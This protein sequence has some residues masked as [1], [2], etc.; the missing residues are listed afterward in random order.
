[1]RLSL[2]DLQPGAYAELRDK[3]SWGLV[4]KLQSNTDTET[5]TVKDADAFI[6]DLLLDLVKEWSLL[7][8]DGVCVGQPAECSAGQLDNVDAELITRIVSAARDVLNRVNPDP[9]LNSAS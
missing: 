8:R 5:G 7:D 4:R 9:N 2:E 1:M 6:S 3:P